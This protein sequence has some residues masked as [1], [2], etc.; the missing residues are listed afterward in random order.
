[1]LVLIC[2]VKRTL[3]RLR[4]AND[5]RGMMDVLEICLRNNFAGSESVRL[6]SEVSLRRLTVH[7]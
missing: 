2:Q 7:G 3:A 1:M 6:Y 4:A 5:V